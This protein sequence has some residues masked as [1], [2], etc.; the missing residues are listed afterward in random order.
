MAKPLHK[1]GFPLFD[2]IAELV[3]G[4]RATGEN[5]FRV[6]QSTQN[7]AASKPTS[8]EPVIDPQLLDMQFEGRSVAGNKG[9]DIQNDTSLNKL[10]D[11]A[12]KMSFFDRERESLISS[13]SNSFIVCI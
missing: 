12:P 13:V 10:V 2:D 9:L 6:G 8:Y 1:K 3:D 7:A 11:T 5:A 4:T